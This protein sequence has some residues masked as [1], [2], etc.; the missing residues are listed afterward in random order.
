MEEEID[1]LT[2][3]ACETSMTVAD[4]FERRDPTAVSAY[5][6][7]YKV[8]IAALDKHGEKLGEMKASHDKFMDQVVMSMEQLQVVTEEVSQLEEEVTAS[9]GQISALKEQVTGATDN[10]RLLANK[11]SRRAY[12][13]E[14]LAHVSEE[15]ES[16]RSELPTYAE[17]IEAEQK[18]QEEFQAEIEILEKKI[19][20]A[21]ST[22]RSKIKKNQMKAS[23][24]EAKIKRSESAS[25]FESVVLK[26]QEPEP[27][28]EA[29]PS[30]IIHRTQDAE[31][32]EVRMLRAE[33]E[34]AITKNAA[35]KAQLRGMAQDL[36]AMHEENVALK[37][38][39][40][41]LEALKK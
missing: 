12:V 23:E 16:M 34:E 5:N 6:D 17:Q 27:V 32:D 25:K 41:N 8:A 26:P 10:N 29:G 3:E 22:S 36:A 39:M 19:A 4:L 30:M 40:R 9:E 7:F 31:A 20:E 21:G 33:M 35:L 1:R 28:E 15:L 2:G 18:K 11:L 37:A 14:E 24:L 13:A 38:V